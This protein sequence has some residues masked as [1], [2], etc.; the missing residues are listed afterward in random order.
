M[1]IARINLGAALRRLR[2]LRGL[3]LADMAYTVGLDPANLSRLERGKQGYSPIVLEKVAHFLGMRLSELFREA[4]REAGD[5]V[6]EEGAGYA[7]SLKKPVIQMAQRYHAA[8][9]SARA[10][11][12]TLLELAA[13]NEL[14]DAMC[15]SLDQLLQ[16]YKGVR[17]KRPAPKKKAIC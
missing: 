16:P 1:K 17:I 2:Q 6:R 12:D 14:P 15:R 9:P 11:V 3:T 7:S 8:S 5:H 4:E 13:Q 10:L